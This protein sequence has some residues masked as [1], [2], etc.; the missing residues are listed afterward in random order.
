MRSAA[1][2]RGF[3]IAILMLLGLLVTP[4]MAQE[5]P[6]AKIRAKQGPWSI[7]AA[8]LI[9]DKSRDVYEA[10]GG[11]VISSR[12]KSIRSERIIY[13]IKTQIIE[14]PEEF[15]FSY[16]RDYIQGKSAKIDL[17]DETGWVKEGRVFIK[18][19]NLSVKGKR[20]EKTGPFSFKAEDAEF[21]TCDL[22]DPD[23]SISCSKVD[24]TYEGYGLAKSVVFRAKGVPVF[25][26]PIFPFPAKK[27]RQSGFLLPDLGHTTLGGYEVDLPLYW[28]PREDFDATVYTHYMSERGVMEGLE[29]RYFSTERIKGMWRVDYLD[30][31]L[32]RKDRIDAGFRAEKRNRW[33]LKAKNDFTLPGAVEGRLDLDLVSDRDYLGEFKS[34]FSSF[35]RVEKSL[36]EFMNRGFVNDKN[37]LT[38]ES[39]LGL[40]RAFDT[41]LVTGETR[42]VQDL[43]LARDETTLSRLPK[44]EA[45]AIKQK[46]FGSPLYWKGDASYTYFYRREGT[47]G[48]RMDLYPR[49]SLPFRVSY[50]DLE[51]SAGA[52]ETFYYLDAYGERPGSDIRD[53]RAHTREIYDL[54]AEA[55]TRFYRIY[56]PRSAGVEKLR[57]EVKPFVKAKYVPYVNQRKN[58]RFDQED[59]MARD[60]TLTY[61]ITSNLLAKYLEGRSEDYSY[62]NPL[63]FT[64]EQT[65]DFNEAERNSE[66]WR[67]KQS[68]SDVRLQAELNF[69]RYLEVEYEAAFSP[70]EYRVTKNE[71]L[72][73]LSDKRG[74][75]LKLDYRYLAK[76]E[77]EKF[78]DRLLKPAK[79]PVSNS[80]EEVG[81]ALTVA[82]SPSMFVDIEKNY[83]ISKGQSLKTGAKL[84][85]KAK[86]WSLTFG[87]EE[88]PGDRRFA[89]TF[90]LE[91][92]G[93]F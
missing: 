57:H 89:V 12:D 56:E 41:V 93:G 30:D 18:E 31:G 49:F 26:T 59:R 80:D 40:T 63:R 38:R 67:G 64:L 79:L 74:D 6:S 27:R 44:I 15:V 42:Y 84:R 75:A 39:I 51:P 86:C 68:F 66:L 8:R 2:K 36:E 43:D 32:S 88:E 20:L 48:H 37:S 10:T 82:L 54:A 81:A 11:V 60:T 29:A 77:K 16:G 58:P 13:N 28:S 4:C 35:D 91:G 24:V 7:Q 87:W 70:Y 34:G 46:L 9:H 22:E 69:P 72:L 76:T 61:G 65:Y 73:N 83:S 1:P 90:T 19:N 45:S 71:L 25:Y 78:L 33:W 52:R 5:K 3:Y 85:L 55:F 14:L 50:L 17:K 53:R 47:R 62:F 21:T 92:L 23:W